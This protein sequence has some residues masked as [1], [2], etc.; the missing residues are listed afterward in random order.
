MILPCPNSL[1]RVSRLASR[2]GPEFDPKWLVTTTR[3]DNW[4]AMSKTR[5]DQHA[6]YVLSCVCGSMI[7]NELFDFSIKDTGSVHLGSWSDYPIS[8]ARPPIYILIIIGPTSDEAGK[9]QILPNTVVSSGAQQWP[10]KVQIE[11]KLRMW[12]LRQ[13]RLDKFANMGPDLCS[14]SLHNVYLIICL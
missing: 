9:S 11:F 4:S 13:T 10:Y 5:P 6:Y 2:L 14:G 1:F 8:L 3:S 12:H 7:L